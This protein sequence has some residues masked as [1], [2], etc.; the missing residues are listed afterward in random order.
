[1]IGMTEYPFGAWVPKP[2]D[3]FAIRC[4]NCICA[5]GKYGVSDEA[6]EICP[7]QA[8]QHLVQLAH[9]IAQSLE[10]GISSG[11]GVVM[12]RQDRLGRKKHRR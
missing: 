11:N 4:D 12:G 3:A 9:R 1:V 2:D 7:P 10:H 6:Q 5:R 8:E